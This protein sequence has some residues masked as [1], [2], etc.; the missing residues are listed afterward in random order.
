VR[1]S[2]AAN[3]ELEGYQ[4]TEAADGGEAL[5]LIEETEFDLVISDVVMP[6]ATGVEVLRGLKRL[7]PDIPFDLDFCVHFRIARVRGGE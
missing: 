4:V 3:L 6:V 7:R 5:K 2:L 1:I